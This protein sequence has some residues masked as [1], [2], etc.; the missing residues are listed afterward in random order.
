MFRN[1]LDEHGVI[2]EEAVN[3]R[4]CIGVDSLLQDRF[5]EMW[6]SACM[7]SGTGKPNEE[8][9]ARLQGGEKADKY[10]AKW[11]L[12]H[13]MTKSHC[14]T[15]KKGGMTPFD[16][17][18]AIRDGKTDRDYVSLFR[19]FAKGFRGRHQLNGRGGF[20][21]PWGFQKK[22]QTLSYQKLTMRKEGF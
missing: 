5:T 20:V 2:H 8:H 3:Q 21:T 14:K 10:V 7:D 4:P 12:E 15:G 16:F 18:R 19:E 1:L 17:L 13:E 6:E 11:G 22:E 9:G